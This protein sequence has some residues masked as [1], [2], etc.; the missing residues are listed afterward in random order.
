MGFSRQQYWSGLP[1]PS[2]GDLPE[3]GNEPWSPALEAGSLPT[4][5]Q[6]N[7]M[8]LEVCIL[9]VFFIELIF[10]MLWRSKESVESI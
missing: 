1:F 5:L 9:N 4:E 2:P 7:H 10:L 3:P 6:E 8:C